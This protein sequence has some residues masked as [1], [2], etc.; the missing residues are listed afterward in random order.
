MD[1]AEHFKIETMILMQQKTEPTDGETT[2]TG[3]ICSV[4]SVSGASEMQS[5]LTQ[6]SPGSASSIS[7][8]GATDADVFIKP[9]SALSTSVMLEPIAWPPNHEFFRLLWEKPT[10]HIARDLKCTPTAVRKHAKI[11][12]FSAPSPGYWNKKVAGIAVEIPKV[13]QDRMMK[14]EADVLAGN[15]SNTRF[16]GR[17]RRASKDRKKLTAIQWP[18]REVL[19]RLLWTKPMIHIARDLGCYHQAVFAKAKSWRLPLP[20]LGYWQRRR[21]GMQPLIPPEVAAIL[22]DP[23]A[24]QTE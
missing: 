13:V 20:G 24:G 21:A 22:T 14:V 4:K 1:E 16:K 7:E 5:E 3:G 19:L 2:F 8:K 6:T 17:K 10:T 9:H 23:N 12:G 15:Q 11:L 18:S